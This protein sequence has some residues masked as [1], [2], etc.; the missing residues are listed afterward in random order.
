MRIETR[1]F[2]LR[3]F[4]ETDQASFR[5]YAQDPRYLAFYG[6]EDRDP[7]HWEALLGS[8]AASA[9]A[10]PRL[11]YH[12]AIVSRTSPGV[13]AGCCRLTRKGRPAGTAELGLELA[14]IHWGRYTYAMEIS[15][16]LLA[17]AFDRLALDEITGVTSSANVPVRRLALW[18]GAEQM[19]E[20]AGSAWMNAHGWTEQ[21][22]HITR[23]AWER[24]LPGGG[25]P[26]NPPP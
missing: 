13:L 7:E 18:F 26:G 6:P 19:G 3:D 22:W 14:A 15:R 9:A 25:G 23:A 16:A 10:K 11:D 1:R 12:L 21:T 8:Y 17:F 24:N 4:E 2:L 5:V 20:D